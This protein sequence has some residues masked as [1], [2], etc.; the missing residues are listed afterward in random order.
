MRLIILVTALVATCFAVSYIG[1]SPEKDSTEV[2][3][4][5]TPQTAPADEDAVG[6]LQIRKC[7]DNHK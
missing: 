4:P 6:C 5:V 1:C 3:E 7:M 2:V